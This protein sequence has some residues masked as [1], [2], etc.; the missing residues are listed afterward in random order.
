[1]AYEGILAKLATLKADID[2]TAAQIAGIVAAVKAIP[3][4]VPV[5][6]VPVPVPIPVPP[7]PAPVSTLP[8]VT[9]TSWKATSLPTTGGWGAFAYDDS[10]WT[11][12]I[13]EGVYGGPPW[14]NQAILP[15]GTTAHWISDHDS[16]GDP[17]NDLTKPV[18]TVY[19]RKRFT[20]TGKATIVVS[21]DDSCT[22]YLDGILVATVTS[23]LRP[24]TAVVT[25]AGP[26]HVLA[27]K[28]VNQGGPGGLIMDVQAGEVIPVPLP[29]PVP[30]PIPTPTPVP[31]T[32]TPIP[33]PNQ[34]GM[35]IGCNFGWEPGWH[36]ASDTFIPN[37]NFATTQNPWQPLLISGISR[38]N[39]PIRMMDM[40][41][42]NTST[43]Q[44][45][46]G[47]T[48][49]TDPL[50]IQVSGETGIAWEWLILACNLARR[51]IWIN[52]PYL[53]DGSDYAKQ[54]A[55]L[56]QQ[57]LDPSLK[58]WIEISNECIWSMF[59]NVNEAFIAKGTAMGL[60]GDRYEKGFRYTAVA[61]ARMFDDFESVFGKNSP[62]VVKVM[63]GQMGNGWLSG[64]HLDQ[65]KKQ[66]QMANAVAIAPY[67][68]SDNIGGTRQSMLGC[69][70]GVKE[71]YDVAH[72]AGI[73]LVCYEGGSQLSQNSDTQSRDPQM[74]Q[75]YIDY[76]NS[77]K[78]Y[79]THFCQYVYSAGPFTSQNAWAVEEYLGAPLSQSHKLRALLDFI[80]MNP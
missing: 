77:I 66:G 42:T 11:A 34:G 30:P 50:N 60:P 80:R 1:M 19:F 13:D 5:P 62:R 63:A 55:L 27:V 16:H 21:C 22:V 14:I 36:A 2:K 31:P 9:D 75:I 3:V 20:G 78:P 71:V 26:D 79:V 58:V 43:V 61:A 18:Q 25:L 76:L 46:A 73:D 4:V 68:Q 12:A 39:G 35:R 74:Y 28:A 15:S 64:I 38:L 44:N 29:V 24:V 69:A 10:K 53:A 7:A 17:T 72:A 51:D 52:V 8:V 37:V 65:L 49:K 23:W 57:Q 70:S 33:V 67:F 6:P 32:P 48:Q 40:T 54:L 47:R 45:W 56:I 41:S 59:T